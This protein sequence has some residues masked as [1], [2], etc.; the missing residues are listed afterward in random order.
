[1]SIRHPVSLDFGWGGVRP[2]KGLLLTHVTASHS[3]SHVGPIADSSPAS[4]S[5][6]QDKPLLPTEQE[7]R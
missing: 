3:V 7:T 6:N 2:L 1:M 5:K 4:N